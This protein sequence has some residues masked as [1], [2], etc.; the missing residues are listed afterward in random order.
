[1]PFH[2]FA[3]LSLALAALAPLPAA[4][5]SADHDL[6]RRMAEPANWAA[7][8]GNYQNWRHT[9]LKQI[10]RDNVARLQLAWQFPTG[11]ERGH[12]GGPLVVGDTLY[13]HTPYPN[14]V[15]AIDLADHSVKWRY[16]P[17]Q[18]EAALSPLC[19][20]TVNRGLAY[21]DGMILL[22]QTDTTLVALDAQTGKERWRVKNGDPAQGETNTNAPHVFDHYVVTG[23][24]GGEYGARGYITAYDLADGH[25]VWRGYST[26]PDADMLM[27]PA[28][29]M[30]WADGHMVAVGKDSSLKS[31]QGD[32]WKYGGS[33]TWGWYAYDPAL[34]LLY[35]GSGNP[36]TWNPLQ[37]PGDNKWSMS[38]W[39]RDIDTGT[40]RWVYQMTPHDEWDYDGVNET[41]LFDAADKSGRK[42]PLLAHFD[43][44]GFAY[45]L[46]RATGELLTA[47]KYDPSVNWATGVDPVSGRPRVDPRYSPEHSGED[48]S[49]EGICPPTIGAKNQAPAAYAPAEEVSPGHP[50]GLFLVPTNHLCMD[51]EVFEVEHVPGQAY[52]GADVRLRA[53]PGDES[54]LGRL[55]AWDAVKGRAVWSHPERFPVWS[56]A[57][58]TA[59]GLVFYGTLD[60]HLKALDVATGKELWTSPELPSGV[61]GNVASWSWQGRQYVGVYAGIGGL[62]ADP[63][64]IVRLAGGKAPSAKGGV[65]MVFALP[66]DDQKA[67]AVSQP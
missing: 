12:E 47:E 22:Q 55:V 26:G 54:E 38:L 16:E 29:S 25:R 2:R 3:L 23:I 19:C 7:Q 67:K 61:V 63:D 20:D 52:T 66:A 30:T 57:L 53:V 10:D 50:S 39:A 56:G 31:W 9:A 1:M 24:A 60:G 59:S 37:R 42:R 18:D 15:T 64:G 40:V 65:L 41:I 43:R 33:T 21:G 36:S 28:R 8:A 5:T 17:Q 4:A 58:T 14:R 48:V 27:D 13:L 32:Q 11:V 62:A 6:P 44:N 34:R 35:Y 45:T 49:T 46:D 51:A